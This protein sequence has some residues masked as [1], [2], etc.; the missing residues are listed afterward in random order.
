M[1]AN[2]QESEYDEYSLLPT[3]WVNKLGE[4]RLSTTPKWRLR[5]AR[6]AMIGI[7]VGLQKAYMG[8]SGYSVQHVLYAIAGILVFTGFAFGRFRRLSWWLTFVVGWWFLAILVSTLVSP[9]RSDISI[10]VGKVYL[11]LAVTI[12]CGMAIADSQDSVR[13]F[14]SLMIITGMV[15]CALAA[16]QITTGS[17]YFLAS[18]EFGIEYGREAAAAG[19]RA[20]GFFGNPNGL[21]HWLLVPIAVMIARIAYPPQQGTGKLPWILLPIL[22]IGMMLSVSRSGIAATALA[23]LMV[24]G[25]RVFKLRILATVVIS[26]MVIGVS[27]LLIAPEVLVGIVERIMEFT[28]DAARLNYVNIALENIAKSPVFGI[29]LYGFWALS[30]GWSAHNGILEPFVELGIF[31]WIPVMLGIGGGV[32]CLWRCARLSR[33]TNT[34]WLWRGWAAGATGLVMSQMIHGSGWRGITTWMVI[35]VGSAGLRT[36]K[37]QMYYEHCYLDYE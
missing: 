35:G 29:G 4:F 18:T 17:M 24:I 32:V 5:M 28:T 19:G 30:G 31:G 21:A 27:S 12:L 20:Y 11:Y 14:T 23:F 13:K 33:G 8:A 37:E 16:I 1:T 6:L 15:S 22:L 10:P 9:F 7:S 34:E 2:Q 3:V 26:G 36:I 25:M